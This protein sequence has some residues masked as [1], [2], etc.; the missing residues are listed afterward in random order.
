MAWEFDRVAGPYR[1]SIDGVVWDGQAV[2]FSV[3]DESRIYRYDPAGA[4]TVFRAYTSRTA[5]LAF[6]PEGTLYGCQTGSRRIA[7]FNRD[8]ST[9]PME[10]RLDS[11]FH[12]YPDDLTID[13]QGRIWFSDPYNRTPSRGPQLQGPLDHASVLRLERRPDRSWLLRRMTF[14]TREPKGVLLS[15]DQHTL[16][17]AE[18]WNAQLEGKRELRAYSIRDDDTLG[19]CV[20]LHT[21]GADHRGPHRGIDGMCLDAEGNIVACA[22]GGQSGPGPIM[23]VFS[24]LSGVIEAHGA[25][26]DRPRN[27]AF[28]DADLAT[29]YVG[30][31]GG[32]LYRVRDTGRRGSA[33]SSPRP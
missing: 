32:C 31:D 30:S 22:G 21:F 26:T 33:A 9:T 2:L 1:G 15:L 7:R 16:F 11:R 5:G 17:V 29:L 6:D 25:P 19:P 27:C 24:P 3:P 12:N 18:S 13:R 20:V 23:Y 28:G 14:D 8:G 4:V 10:Y